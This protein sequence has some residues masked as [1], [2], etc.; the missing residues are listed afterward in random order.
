MGH[1]RG[2]G[3][4]N[5]NMAIENIFFVNCCFVSAFANTRLDKLK[6]IEVIYKIIYGFLVR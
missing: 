1:A 6:F 5:F 2:R 4:Q 3:C